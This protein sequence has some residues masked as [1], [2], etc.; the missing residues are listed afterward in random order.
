MM[1]IQYS[2]AFF[3]HKLTYILRPDITLCVTEI[4][5]RE[6]GKTLIRTRTLT[7]LV[8]TSSVRQ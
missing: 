7:F 3:I 8:L 1:Y 5:I 4:L 6:P 2:A